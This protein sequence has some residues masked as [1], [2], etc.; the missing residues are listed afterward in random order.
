M[1]IR[2]LSVASRR[3]S[4]GCSG[5]SSPRARSRVRPPLIRSADL[6][7]GGFVSHTTP[8]IYYRVHF[9]SIVYDQNVPVLMQY[10]I[11][12]L[13]IWDTDGGLCALGPC[14]VNGIG[15]HQW[16]VE[17]TAAL[18]VTPYLPDP[19]NPG[20]T[21]LGMIST[22]PSDYSVIAY[23]LS[24]H[25]NILCFD[26]TND[27]I[28][29]NPV[30]GVSFHPE[31][32][33]TRKKHANYS[34]QFFLNSFFFD[35]SSQVNYYPIF[36]CLGDEYCFSG[37]LCVPVPCIVECLS[38]NVGEAQPTA[39]NMINVGELT[40]PTPGS[41]WILDDRVKNKLEQPFI[42]ILNR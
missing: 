15:G 42:K 29:R 28:I 4:S 8:L 19:A 26:N 1:T 18:L 7:C 36:T 14:P 27:L 17:R 30:G 34:L 32:I 22:N 38:V 33:W 31:F 9:V 41:S 2:F 11:D 16:D 40:A 20:R 12:Y 23:R 5:R 37:G 10:I 3:P 25:E 21:D 24:A 35:S 13:T 6:A 39:S